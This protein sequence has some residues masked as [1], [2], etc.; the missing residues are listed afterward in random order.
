MQ[1]WHPTES[2][3]L[4]IYK[5]LNDLVV[6]GENISISTPHEF[7]I[8]E[9]KNQLS[10]LVKKVD[11]SVDKT[12]VLK[13][14]ELYIIEIFEWFGKETKVEIIQSLA[15]TIYRNY[16]WLKLTE[17]KL[18]VEKIKSGQWKQIHSLSAAVIMERLADFADESMNLREQI[19]DREFVQHEDKMSD[20]V[21]V[22][23]NQF[24]QEMAA[25]YIPDESKTEQELRDEIHKHADKTNTWHRENEFCMKWLRDNKVFEQVAIHWYMLFL[26]RKQ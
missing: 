3:S 12:K 16:Y 23:F 22:L 6:N 14:I 10:S 2:N 5:E 18:F 20:E 25:K 24:A 1:T 9:D 7:C 17:L 21:K 11:D 8:K 26:K 15:A 4:T 19:G 13:L